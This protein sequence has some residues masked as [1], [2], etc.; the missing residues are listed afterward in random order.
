MLIVGHGEQVLQMVVYVPDSDF[1]GTDHL[2][3]SVSDLGNSGKANSPTLKP[4][5]NPNP[6]PTLIPKP[7]TVPRMAR[8]LALLWRAHTLNPNP[9]N[10]TP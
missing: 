2:H 10:L 3:I 4:A 5:M 7:E 9:P 6:N 8:R 1:F